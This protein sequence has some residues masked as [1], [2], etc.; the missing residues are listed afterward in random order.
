MSI[1][2]VSFIILVI[3]IYN[4]YKIKKKEYSKLLDFKEG[5]INKNSLDINFIDNNFYIKPDKLITKNFVFSKTKYLYGNYNFSLENKFGYELSRIYDIENMN[6]NLSK[7]IDLLQE[8]SDNYDGKQEN[9]N[10]YMCL[11]SNYYKK[12]LY[13]CPAEPVV[14]QVGS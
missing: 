4:L 9:N 3:I 8:Y 6:S 13:V 2:S 5:Y 1:F 11:E 12:I 10:V 7:N 14:Y